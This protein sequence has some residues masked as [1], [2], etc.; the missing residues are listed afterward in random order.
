LLNYTYGTNLGISKSSVLINIIDT[1]EIRDDILLAKSYNPDGII[2]FFHW[3]EEYHRLPNAAQTEVA[4]FCFKNGANYLIGSHP[5]VI[6]PMIKNVLDS[7]NNVESVVYYSLGNFISNQRD[8]NTDGGAIAYL[9]FTKKQN[10]I[11]INRA[12]Y[13]LSWTWKKLLMI[14]MF[15]SVYHLGNSIN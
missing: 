6:Q 10:K 15:T 2:I 4:N 7:S 9:E 8:I 11:H 12:G 1:N 14:N 3:G 5:H 13:L